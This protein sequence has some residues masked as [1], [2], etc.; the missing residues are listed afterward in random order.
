MFVCRW[1]WLFGLLWRDPGVPPWHRPVEAGWPYDG[2]KIHARCLHHQ[3]CRCHCL[4][5]DTSKW[6]GQY[7][8]QINETLLRG[9]FLHYY[10]VVDMLC[11][12]NKTLF[13]HIFRIYHFFVSTNFCSITY[14]YSKLDITI[15][16]WC[17]IV[18]SYLFRPA[19]AGR[20]WESINK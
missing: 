9:F 17:C 3:L 8:V 5:L 13:Q 6:I 19:A 4:V 2:T 12:I 14:V 1:Q 11:S 16:D 7:Q 15:L 10:S 18:L 20:D